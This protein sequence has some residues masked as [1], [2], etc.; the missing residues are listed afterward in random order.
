MGNIDKSDAIF[1]C[2]MFGASCSFFTFGF[3]AAVGA[4][5]ALSDSD[6][7]FTAGVLV[8]IA[9]LVLGYYSIRNICLGKSDFNNCD[10]KWRNFFYCDILSNWIQK[11]HILENFIVFYLFKIYTICSKSSN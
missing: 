8:M 1:W 6:W 5:R 9:T 7:M 2:I 11:T 3:F 10:Q 4:L